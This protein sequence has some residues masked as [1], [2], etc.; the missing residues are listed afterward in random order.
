MNV[1]SWVTFL[2]PRESN[3]SS[4]KNFLSQ[5]NSACKTTNLRTSGKIVFRSPMGKDGK[6]KELVAQSCQYPAH[7]WERKKYLN[8]L[9]Q[10]IFNSGKLWR[11]NTPYYQDA[12]Q[13][14]W[15]YLVRNLC[16]GTTC[17]A[18]DPA[19]SSITTWLNKYLRYRLLDFSTQKQK[20]RRLS[21]RLTANNPKPFT[22]IPQEVPNIL[23][24]TKTWVENDPKGELAQ[25]H[26]KKRPDIT[27]QRVIL[28]RLPPETGWEELAKEFNCSLST[29][30]SFYKRKC[31]P[32]LRQF[33]QSQGYI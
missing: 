32:R 9:I 21:E 10:A 33:A 7:S 2:N 26:M 25:T 8:R 18:Y 31:R 15:L 30:Y 19:R 16:E 12:L 20:D 13:Q 17:E 5:L 23:E 4:E 24:E 22:E 27:C 11:E 29:L 1:T 28:R 14:T 6:L 3:F